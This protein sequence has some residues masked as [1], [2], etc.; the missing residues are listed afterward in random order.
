MQRKSIFLAL[1]TNTLHLKKP[2]PYSNS[3]CM[4]H[5]FSCHIL[6]PSSMAQDFQPVFVYLPSQSPLHLISSSGFSRANQGCPLTG[7]GRRHVVELDGQWSCCKYGAYALLSV[8]VHSWSDVPQRFPC[9]ASLQTLV[10]G[11]SVFFSAARI[12]N[13]H[14]KY[15]FWDVYLFELLGDFPH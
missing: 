9:S 12:V 11:Q 6:F 3:V 2:K 4:E 1:P 8:G 7:A 15:Q 10:F 5:A 13:Q 14:T